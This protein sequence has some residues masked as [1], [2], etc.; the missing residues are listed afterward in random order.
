[1]NRRNP[2]GKRLLT[3][4]A[5][6]LAALN[7][8]AA[9]TA[10]LEHQLD[11]IDKELGQLA[12]YTMRSGVGNLG[13][14]SDDHPSPDHT[15]WVE[16]KLRE[17]TII[18]LIVLAP[19][20]WMD[21]NRG[22][23][24]DGFPLEFRIIAGSEQHPDGKVIAAFTEND[25]VLPRIAPLVIPLNPTN[26][27]WV[28][29]EATK[30]SPW[31]WN[32]GQYIFQLSEVLIYS[33]NQNAALHRAVTASSSK[34]NRVHRAAQK[35]ALTDG[36]MPYLMD[37]A[38][39]ERSDPYL[40]FFKPDEA[41]RLTI[42]LGRAISI[43]RINLHTADLR[44]N[45]PRI[46]HADY[47]I[48]L[49]LHI[50]GSLNPDYSSA[51]PIAK[52]QREQIY[53]TGPITTLNFPPITVRYVHL[54]PTQGY[55]APEADPG[56]WRCM[57]FAEVE[58]FSNNWNAALGAHTILND[59]EKPNQGNLSALTDGRNHFGTIL[60]IREWLNQL[61]RRHELEALRPDV[62]AQ[63]NASYLKQKKQVKL[64]SLLVSILSFC[65]AF[66]IGIQYLVHR[67]KVRKLKEQFAADLHDEI[68]A[69]LHTIGLLSDM[70]EESREAPATISEYVK[71]IR[72]VTERTGTAV[73]YVT[74]IHDS[75]ELFSDLKSDM[76]RAAERIVTKQKHNLIIEGESLIPK[77]K[78]R[79]RIN[80]FL[81]YK[82]CL[83][84]ISRHSGATELKTELTLT[85]K[86][87]VLSITD[88]GKGLAQDIPKSLQRRAKLFRA[89]VHKE[90]PP[91]GG[92][93][94]TLH[95]KSAGIWNKR[96]AHEA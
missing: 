92:T 48:P 8:A 20:I 68:G 31:A 34:R 94:I 79:T 29:V 19:I 28:R 66:A 81:F 26:A 2:V 47:G 62:E 33:G 15:E 32:R 1:M 9:S 73:R 56:I 45:I 85:P 76:Q 89:R 38:T 69:N 72:A 53:D 64:L 6:Y 59:E 11:A 4:G 70:V 96:P 22:P 78:Q 82:E 83:I 84:N 40:A 86:R 88:D 21:E 61:A 60:P 36:H 74:G 77:L 39:G 80:L 25:H 18:D 95:L 43:N 57:G 44:E 91:K 16:I 67:K 13:W 14:L 7:G 12:E 49:H 52:H 58:I 65:T 46:H 55:K 42:D 63:L 3:A 10:E 50:E 27:T 71:R 17:E 93:Q 51:I 75:P 5:L 35:E 23:V 87:V 24:A 54:T 37:A 41:P 30:L 90:T